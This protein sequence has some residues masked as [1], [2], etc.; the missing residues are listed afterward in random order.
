MEEIRFFLEKNYAISNIPYN[1]FD[2]KKN[3]IIFCDEIS[4]KKQVKILLKVFSEYE[5]DLEKI[6]IIIIKD[7]YYGFFKDKLKNLIFFGPTNFINLKKLKDVVLITYVFVFGT[8]PTEENINITS[9]KQNPYSSLELISSLD[10]LD[11][12]DLRR[13][14]FDDELKFMECIKNG[15]LNGFSKIDN[16]IEKNYEAAKVG[17]L[18]KNNLKQIEYIACSTITL[19]TRAGINGGLDVMTAY[20]ISDYYFQKLECTKTE[21]EINELLTELIFE[22]TNKVNEKKKNSNNLYVVKCKNYISRHRNKKIILNEIA[23]YIGISKSH[24]SKLFFEDEG[25]SI[26]KYILNMRLEMGSN[27]LKNSD[28][29]LTDIA[30]YLCFNSQ[31]HFGKLFKE[32]YGITPNEYRRKNKIIDF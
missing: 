23:D 15:D 26:H 31:S 21:L 3:E 17:R 27:L 25:V 7:C 18:A 1:Y 6:N 16:S 20:G 22:I 30:E 9:L 13:N 4:K 5:I 14:N 24:L 8:K 11:S 29:S 28:E 19:A 12:T 10:E 32:K 2:L